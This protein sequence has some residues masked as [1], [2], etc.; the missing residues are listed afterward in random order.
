MR[1]ASSRWRAGGRPTRRSPSSPAATDGLGRAVARELA[2]RGAT[3]LA[4]GRD[5]ERLERTVAELRAETAN[6][7]VEARLAD[8]AELARV[9]ALAEAVERSVPNLHL[10]INNAGIG[11]GRPEGRGRQE[12]HDGH[13]LRFAVNYLAPFLLTERLLGLLR[14]SAPARIVNVASLGQY[15]IDFEDPMLTRGYDGTRA[16]SRSKLAQVIHTADLAGRLP[17]AELS[18]NSLHPGTYMPT[19]I[20]LAER[21]ESVDS[22][23]TGTDSVLRLGLD[24]ELEGRS[25]GF[26]DR[27]READPNPQATD[28]EAQRR[29]REL[30]ERL[31]AE[32]LAGGGYPRASASPSRPR[33]GRSRPDGERLADRWPQSPRARRY[34]GR[35]RSRWSSS[36]R[37]CS[38]SPRSRSGR[39]ARP[40]RRTAG[41]RPAPACSR[42]SRSAMRSPTSSSTSSTRTSTSRPSSRTA[43]RRRWR[44]SRARSPRRCGRRSAT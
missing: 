39:S 25:G 36:P 23:E 41:S 9:A 7:R 44:S 29:L 16:Y 15:P 17:A 8:F 21:G 19:K 30:S 33:A 24:P 4:H 14:G 38:W 3:V 5:P 6:E 13:E 43:C 1:A 22:I 18:V 12:S 27:S 37:C 11:G 20:V 28:R 31:V 40:W 35:C 26:Y 42:T 32:T 34:A 10:L 2:A